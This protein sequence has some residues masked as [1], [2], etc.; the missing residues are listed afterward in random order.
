[1]MRR[2]ATSLVPRLLSSGQGA[3]SLT[4]FNQVPAF[5]FGDDKHSSRGE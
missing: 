1:M 5:S 4:A 2:V 3:A